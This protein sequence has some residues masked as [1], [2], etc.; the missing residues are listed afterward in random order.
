ME[1]K[2]SEYFDSIR[3]IATVLVVV[4]H[5]IQVSLPSTFDDN[6]IFKLIYSFHMPLFMFISGMVTFK[7][8]RDIT[9]KWLYKRFKVLIIPFLIWIFIP[10]F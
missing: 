9:L 4:G 7:E 5:A 2:R 6:V 8:E 3:G 1:G 10:F